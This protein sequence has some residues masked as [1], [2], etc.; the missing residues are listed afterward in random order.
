MLAA[1]IATETGNQPNRL[2]QVGWRFE[3]IGLGVGL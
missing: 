3:V 2:A 1:R